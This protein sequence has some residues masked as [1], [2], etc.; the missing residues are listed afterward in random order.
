MNK[1][2][3]KVNYS[4]RMSWNLDNSTYLVICTGF[5]TF[6]EVKYDIFVIKLINN[7]FKQP[8]DGCKYQTWKL[9][10]CKHWKCSKKTKPMWI[11]GKI[12]R[13]KKEKKWSKH[14]LEKLTANSGH[15]TLT[16]SIVLIESKTAFTH[17]APPLEKFSKTTRF[18]VMFSTGCTCYT[19]VMAS[20]N[21]K[22]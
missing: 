14:Q 18:A 1:L 13:C 20:Y 11:N 21:K 5:L 10:W 3:T 2:T 7:P 19:A 22:E 12:L 6:C 16:F 8:C 9:L 15:N 17:T 4:F